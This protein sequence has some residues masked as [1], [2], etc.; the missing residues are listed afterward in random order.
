MTLS[1]E[2]LPQTDGINSNFAKLVNGPK[3]LVTATWVSLA[4]GFLTNASINKI[5]SSVGD[6]SL[7]AHQM[8]VNIPYSA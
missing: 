8:L 4:I 3:V 2:I 1:N 7:F 5:I 6:I